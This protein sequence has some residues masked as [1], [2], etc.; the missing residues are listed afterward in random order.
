MARMLQHVTLEVREE[1]VRPCVAFWAL[2][3]F[4]EMT[5]PAALA[6]EF[7]WV[8]RAGTQIHLV[9]VAAP[10]VAQRG[11]VAVIAD[12]YA[13]TVR[14]LDEA[15]FAPQPGKRA[16]DADRVFV[17][18]PAGHRVEIM[19]APPEPPWPEDDAGA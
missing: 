17:R 19:E 13:A 9:P 6:G 5:P 10:A 2:V 11:H 3:G 16:W 15:G 18:D 4:E 12:D 7:T 8:H 14:R 1:D